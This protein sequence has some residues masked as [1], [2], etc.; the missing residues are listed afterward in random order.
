M[1][2]EKNNYSGAVALMCAI[3][4]FMGA[5]GIGRAKK[6]PVPEVTTEVIETVKYVEVIPDNIFDTSSIESWEGDFT[7]GKIRMVGAWLYGK[8][9][10]GNPIVIDEKN[11]LWTVGGYDIKED[12]FLLLW[13][14]D[15]NT[16][17]YVHDDLILKIWNEKHQGVIYEEVG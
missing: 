1:R 17:D 15:S 14:S 10:S 3:A 7:S 11:E 13:V 6:H 12:D 4:L 5:F 16:P 9:N 2:A 8:D